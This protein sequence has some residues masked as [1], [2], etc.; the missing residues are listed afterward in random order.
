MTS[1]DNDEQFA[2]QWRQRSRSFDAWAVDYDRYR[3]TYPQTLFDHVAAR[4]SLPPNARVADLGSGTG[5]AARQMA[6]RGW[7]VTAVEPGEGMLD[8]LRARADLEQLPIDARLAPAEDTEL[9]DASVDLATAAQAFHWFDKPRAVAEMARI[10]KPGGGAAVFWN[11][12]ADDRS[13]FLAAHTDLTARYLSE[14]HVDRRTRKSTARKD[15]SDGGFFDV[16]DRVEVAHELVMSSDE[17]VAY[18]FTASQIRLFVEP[19]DQERLKVDI[20]ENIRAHFGDDPVT[21]PYDVDLY[22]GSR[23]EVPA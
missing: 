11:A 10:V 20:R 8:V 5:K 2:E 16:D 21:V 15:L 23:T 1:T 6:R 3:P 14:A 12:R 19:D 7:H 17:F 18:V 22:V 9:P 4:L 13:A